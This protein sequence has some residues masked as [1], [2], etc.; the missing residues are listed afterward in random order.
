MPHHEAKGI[1]AMKEEYRL[2]FRL[3]EEKDYPAVLDIQR[4]AYQ[5]KEVP[6]YGDNLPPLGETPDSIREELAKGKQLLVAEH[7]GVVVG[8]MRFAMQEDGTVYWGRL[9]VDPDLQGRGIGQ[10]LVAAVEEMHPEAS[11]FVLDCGEKSAENFHIYS[12][13]GY[14]KTGEGFQV[15][16]G[17]YVLVMRKGR[18]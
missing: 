10:R 8:S 6:L 1:T 18:A 2:T 5:L 15:P 4:R 14:V 13:M 11:G 7:D 3:G 17:P 12:K 9:S 16:G